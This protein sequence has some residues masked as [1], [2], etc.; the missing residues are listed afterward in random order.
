MGRIIA[1]AVN[2]ILPVKVN[3]VGSISNQHFDYITSYSRKLSG[4]S[5]QVVADNLVHNSTSNFHYKQ[6]T[7]PSSLEVAKHGNPP[8]SQI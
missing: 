7:Q 4:L 1:V 2:S 8:K 5:G 3:A 6:F